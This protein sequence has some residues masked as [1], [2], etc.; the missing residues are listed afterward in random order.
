MDSANFVN[1]DYPMYF[2]NYIKTY[3]LT[4]VLNLAID[5]TNKYIDCLKSETCNSGDGDECVV[6]EKDKNSQVNR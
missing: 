2:E 6:I 4:F 3:I 5:S 1:Y